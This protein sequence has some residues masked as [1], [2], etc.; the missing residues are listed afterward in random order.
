MND[1]DPV[2]PLA[3]F[4][5]RWRIDNRRDGFALFSAEL[6]PSVTSLIYVVAQSPKILAERIM[7]IERGLDEPDGVL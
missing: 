3:P 5:G 2:D 7:Q 4:R 1:L 6:Q